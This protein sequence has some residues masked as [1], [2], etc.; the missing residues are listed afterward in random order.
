M[1]PGREDTPS[2]GGAS[3][4]DSS[5]GEAHLPRSV[6]QGTGLSRASHQVLPSP[7]SL[8]PGT[9]W[10]SRGSP[11]PACVAVGVAGSRKSSSAS[12]LDMA[13]SE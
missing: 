5:L 7:P 10:G 11:C 8:G 13:P 6:L 12:E 9:S 3:G 4:V 2:A 1:T